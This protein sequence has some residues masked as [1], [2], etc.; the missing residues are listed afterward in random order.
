MR[1]RNRYRYGMLSLAEDYETSVNSQALRKRLQDLDAA[2]EV[3]ILDS[4]ENK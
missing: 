3:A 4:F 2:R 1:L